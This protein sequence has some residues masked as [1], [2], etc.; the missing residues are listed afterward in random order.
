M[1]WWFA[2][3][4]MLAYCWMNL[5]VLR[6]ETVVT[7]VSGVIIAFFFY[8]EIA[9]YSFIPCCLKVHSFPWCLFEG[10]THLMNNIYTVYIISAVSLRS[11]FGWWWW[12]GEWILLLRWVLLIRKHLV[13]F[14][15]GIVLLSLHMFFREEYVLRVA[16]ITL[17]FILQNKSNK[18]WCDIKYIYF[19][20]FQVPY[21]VNK[22]HRP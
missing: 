18:T 8:L 14:K 21:L 19:E 20:E 9:L 12:Y 10:D 16:T 1:A 11:S 5:I 13:A 3:A 6:V 2:F 7:L 4:F 15:K 22:Q 17:P